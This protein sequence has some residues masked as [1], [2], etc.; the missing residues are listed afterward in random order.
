LAT[1]SRPR[2][3]LV[4]SGTS[5]TNIS[6]VLGFLSSE[7]GVATAKFEDY[8][9]EVFR[10]PIYHVAELLLVGYRSAAERFEKAFNA[11]MEDLSPSDEAVIGAH[12]VYYRRNNIIVSPVVALLLRSL[13]ERSIAVIDYVDDY[14]HVL[15]RVAERAARGETPE[16]TGF[17]VLDPAGLIHWRGSHHSVAQLLQLQGAEVAIY[18]S[19]H[20]RTGHARLAAKL[21]GRKTEEGRSYET[22]YISHPITKVREKAAKEG[23]PLSRHPDALDI[24]GFKKRLEESC[25]HIVVYSPTTIDELIPGPDGEP[26]ATRIEREARWPHPENGIHEYPYPVDLS[27]KLFDDTIYPVKRTVGNPGYLE[28]LR[29]EIEASIERRDLGYVTQ[30][31]FVVA[32]RPSMYGTHHM[33]VETEIK[34]AI[35]TAKPVYSVVPPEERKVPYTLFRF[36]YPLA[37]VE[38]L[39]RVL[40]C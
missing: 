39:L 40:R 5:G 18:A 19:K 3:L 27:S 15:H 8:V 37:S 34:T 33:G 28:I 12:L 6:R 13:K 11:M 25:S 16:V 9:E 31:D 24:E 30:A 26:L 23:V 1:G 38:E 17:Q 14:Y 7:L 10:A 35:A 4:I 22:V 36:E 32:Y 21:L 2:R 20:S 29:S